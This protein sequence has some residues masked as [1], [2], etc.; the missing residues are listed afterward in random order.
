MT[1]AVLNLPGSFNGTAFYQ[2]ILAED[3]LKKRCTTK[4]RIRL[5]LLNDI[6]AVATPEEPFVPDS[7]YISRYQEWQGGDGVNPRCHGEWC[8][9]PL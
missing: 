3:A 2:A 7:Y 8:I 6:T 1:L 4:E 9:H 5:K